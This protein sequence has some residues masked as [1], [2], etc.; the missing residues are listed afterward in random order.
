MVLTVVGN[1]ERETKSY[2]EDKDRHSLITSWT[3][4]KAEE[5]D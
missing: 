5:N 3:D 1:E 4:I 2:M